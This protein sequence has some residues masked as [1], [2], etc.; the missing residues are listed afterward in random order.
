MESQSQ[1]TLVTILE[2]VYEV[3]VYSLIRINIILIWSAGELVS[4]SCP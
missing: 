2:L 3:Y 4:F 1:E